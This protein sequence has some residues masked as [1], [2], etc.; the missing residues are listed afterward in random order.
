MT[1]QTPAKTTTR[2][3]VRALGSKHDYARRY[4]VVD[5]TTGKRVDGV[6]GGLREQE[7]RDTA[8]DLNGVDPYADSYE[9]P[10][11]GEGHDGMTTGTEYCPGCTE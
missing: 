7:A 3:R 11:C 10:D 6:R 5:L 1:A 9:C 4:G 2:Y 8:D